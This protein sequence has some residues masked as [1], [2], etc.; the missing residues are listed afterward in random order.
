MPAAGEMIHIDVAHRSQIPSDEK[1]PQQEP[2]VTDSVHDERLIRRIARR[3]ALEIESDQQVRT[4]SYALPPHKHQH[5]VVRQDQRQHRE[6][7]KVQVSK[8]PVIPALVRHV[9]GRI[10]MDEHPDAGDEEQ[11]DAR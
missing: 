2:G 9:P 5:I 11:P 1:H 4:Q 7:E 6:H 3:L 10:D 8:K